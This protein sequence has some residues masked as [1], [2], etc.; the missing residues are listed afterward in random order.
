M[1]TE[2]SGINRLTM[3]ASF[4]A[5]C[6]ASVVHAQRVI[7]VDDSAP[8][9]GNGTSWGTAFND[10]Q[11]AINSITAPG[12]D[13]EIRMGQGV[14]IPGGT[15][16]ARDLR[17]E[18]KLPLGGSAITVA[19]KGGYAGVGAA[20]PDAHD[21]TAFAS[22]LTA[23]V[24]GNDDLANFTTWSDNRY[25]TLAL[26]GAKRVVLD[27]LQIRGG[28]YNGVV[29]HYE[30]ADVDIRDC[31]FE[32]NI[33]PA[34]WRVGD[35][36]V[37]GCKFFNNRGGDIQVTSNR[38]ISDISVA[39]SKFFGASQ[40]LTIRTTYLS[41]ERCEFAGSGTAGRITA[42]QARLASNLFR[43]TAPY[44]QISIAPPYATLSPALPAARQYMIVGNTFAPSLR[45]LYMETP[46]PPSEARYDLY[47]NIFGGS[48]ETQFSPLP[49][50][51]ALRNIFMIGPGI[52]IEPIVASPAEV[53]ADWDGP[54]N[55]PL[56]TDDND[57][58]P[59]AGGPAIDGGFAFFDLFLGPT[60]VFGNDRTRDGNGDGVAI[61]D[62]GAI[63][64]SLPCPADLDG[65]GVVNDADFAVFATAY[66]HYLDPVGDFNG[67][68]YTDDADFVIFATAYDTFDCP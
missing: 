9:G 12:P 39:F 53:F 10:L 45:A 17:Y 52:G 35:M 25:Y 29:A 6:T 66:D 61:P 26:F 56:T 67:D 62:I 58:T 20:N 36:T 50:Q 33:G 11:V 37:S 68:G 21:P 51:A 14:Y 8:A 30:F 32:R 13:I 4:M 7:Y 5:L 48:V 27:G 63:E 19:I 65:N 15:A 60:D 49:L 43:S 64:F 34:L 3:A 47:G 40:A 24:L 59:R 18:L 28:V 44:S 38:T 42:V 2:S 16:S 55:N 41:V 23:D 1:R 31:R 54:D 57:Y 46:T 22:V